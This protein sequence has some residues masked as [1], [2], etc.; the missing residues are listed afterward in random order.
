MTQASRFYVSFD[1]LLMR[2]FASDMMVKLV[3]GMGNE[4]L[5]NKMFTNA[6]SGAQKRIEGQNFDTRKNLLEYDDVLAKQRA[7]VYKKRDS[8]LFAEDIKDLIQ[9]Q[10]TLTANFLARKAIPEGSKDTLVSG[11]LL[12][13]VLEPNYLAEGTIKPS[14]Y[15]DSPVEEIAEDLMLLMYRRYQQRRK[16]W[17][18]EI[19]DKVEREITLRAI[20]R[21][22]TTHIDTMAHLREGIHLRS[23]ANTNPLQDYVN[24]G[25]TLFG[26]AMDNI[27]VESVLQLLNAKINLP[28]PVTEEALNAETQSD[29]APKAD[30]QAEEE[31]KDENN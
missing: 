10:F 27:A 31:V 30:V 20:D 28:P 26:E 21:N 6:I 9:E 13:R 7:A 4:A 29:A 18:E 14:A 3:A 12:K 24:E 2:R 1:D 17:P 8:I 23:Y 22:W 11:A 16:D 5:E 19:A 15:D 25:Y